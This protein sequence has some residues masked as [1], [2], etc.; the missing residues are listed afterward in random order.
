M[1]SLNQS[2]LGTS[3]KASVEKRG[4]TIS[5]LAVLLLAV[6][7]VSIFVFISAKGLP[8]F[9]ND[10]VQLSQFFFGDQWS[11]GKTN[12]QGFSLVGVLPMLVGST[13]VTLLA[14]VMVTPLAIATG[15]F[16]TELSPKIG[17]YIL[18]PLLEL[19]VGIPSVV[20]GFVGLSV[21][22][23]FMRNTF[24]GSG[25]GILAGG[26]VLAMMILPTVASMTVDALNRVPKHLKHSSL[27]LGANEFQTMYRVTLRVAKPGI[28][29]GVV[30]GLARAFGEALAVQMVIGNAIVIPDS[31]VMPA[32]T[33]TSVLTQGMGNTIMGTFEN[34][35]LWTLAFILLFMS[36]VFNLIIKRISQKG[37][38]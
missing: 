25:F 24:G 26:I 1:S 18:Q 17:K 28:L 6:T 33:L 4:H 32:T 16:I 3:K 2:L 7:V 36:L 19:L 21:V 37:Q 11:P 31:L 10:K 35:A 30:F 12:E 34:D 9:F 14:L 38:V 23:P 13:A 29:T 15:L 8:L 5:L 22:V 20:Y 27:A